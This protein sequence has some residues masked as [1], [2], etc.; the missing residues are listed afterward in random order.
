[1][2]KGSHP[3]QSPALRSAP[4]FNEP[5]Y[6]LSFSFIFLYLIFPQYFYMY[7]YLFVCGI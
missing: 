4:G 5:F 7:H 3:H 1:M 6:F 2:A